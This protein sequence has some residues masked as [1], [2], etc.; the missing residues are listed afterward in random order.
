[1][2]KSQIT[3]YPNPTTDFITIK[4]DDEYLEEIK[5]YDI[6]GELIHVY[7]VKGLKKYAI[8]LSYLPLGDYN[9][10][11]CLKNSIISNQIITK[12]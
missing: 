8:S 2:L 9:T 11:I 1:M 12:N 4:N 7:V 10:V 6:M 5:L 3:C